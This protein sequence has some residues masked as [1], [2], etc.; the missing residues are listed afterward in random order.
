MVAKSSFA[1]QEAIHPSLAFVP[2]ILLF[3]RAPVPLRHSGTISRDGPAKNL[4]NRYSF[5]FDQRLTHC[6]ATFL[7]F[8][9][10]PG[11]VVCPCS[12]L[13]A[14]R[15]MSTWICE[16]GGVFG[17]PLASDVSATA[18]IAPAQRPLQSNVSFRAGLCSEHSSA[19][20]AEFIRG[21][22]QIQRR[23]WSPPRVLGSSIHPSTAT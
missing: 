20:I 14:N 18:S 6:D 19:S 17:D 4:C 23:S 13:P 12:P 11:L 22:L 1:S 2:C 9:L 3:R 16:R 7:P 5:L 8:R 15:C 21:S 10:D